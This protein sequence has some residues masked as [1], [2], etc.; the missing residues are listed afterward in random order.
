MVRVNKE[1]I[2]ISF[3]ILII[4]SVFLQTWSLAGSELINSKLKSYQSDDNYPLNYD[5]DDNEVELDEIKSGIFLVF[6]ASVTSPYWLPIAFIDDGSFRYQNY[7]FEKNDSFLS[8]SGRTWMMNYSLST[9][10]I[11]K[12]E[13]G[14]LFKSSIS[15]LRLTVEPYYQLYQKDD[16]SSDYLSYGGQVLLTFAQNHLFCFR[17]GFGYNHFENQFKHDGINWEYEANIYRKNLHLKWITY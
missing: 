3:Y 7:P 8:E 6:I 15:Y 2:V 13:R 12:D 14:L 9:Q 16:D 5:E 4:V 1:P 11:K 10:Y 17:S